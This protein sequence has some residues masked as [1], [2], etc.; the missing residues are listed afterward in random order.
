MSDKDNKD[1][2]QMDPAEYERIMNLP[3]RTYQFGGEVRRGHYD[4]AE[5]MFYFVDNE[6]ERVLR[7]KR[8]PPDKGSYWTKKLNNPDGEAPKSKLS[9]NDLSDLMKSLKGSQKKKRKAAAEDEVTYKKKGSGEAINPDG[10]T[11]QQAKKKKMMLLGMAALFVFLIVAGVYSMSGVTSSRTPEE[12]LPPSSATEESGD[13][14]NI[15]VVQV[16]RD[17]VPGEVIK[18][19]DIQESTISSQ[20][21]NEITLGD[22]KLYQWDRADSLIDKYV[23]SYIPK[24]QYLTYD[25]IDT[26][27]APEPNPW[28]ADMEGYELVS[29]PV[30]DE[31]RGNKQLMYGSMLSLSITKRTVNEA[32]LDPEEAEEKSSLNH[33]ASVEQSYIIDTYTLDATVC[34]LLNESGDSLYETFYSWIS[35]PAGEQANYLKNAFME[36]ESLEEE[37]EP[38]FISI[39]VTPEQ[40]EDLGEILTDDSEITYKFS[41]EMNQGTD[42]KAAFIAETE[43]LFETIGKAEDAAKKALEEKAAEEK[44]AA[45]SE[46]GE[47]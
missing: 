18:A 8:V 27:Y 28:T 41:S 22:S 20:S 29:I 26:V 16:T 31:V 39:K 33:E 25:N 43:A 40:A 2:I 17:L 37:I 10:I 4:E 12:A 11:P 32:N 6:N 36:D 35:I 3:E 44:A 38:A 34:D 14:D 30:T 19:S 1:K 47:N 24:G 46:E 9:L 15:V 7:R 13:L 5:R 45:E 23:V 21:Y 42:A